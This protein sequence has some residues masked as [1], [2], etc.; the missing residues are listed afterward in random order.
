MRP[1][2]R[3]GKDDSITVQALTKRAL[4]KY[5][6]ITKEVDLYNRNTTKHFEHN[7]WYLTI[8]GVYS[9]TFIFKG[10][11][12]GVGKLMIPDSELETL[13]LKKRLIEEYK[14][15]Y[16]KVWNKYKLYYGTNIIMEY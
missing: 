16:P 4:F 7:V 13:T 1:L 15:H 5:D 2:K 12:R 3:L 11:S 14:K 6:P 9:T 10:L 8:E